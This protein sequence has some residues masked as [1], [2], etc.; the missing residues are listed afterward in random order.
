MSRARWTGRLAGSLTGA[1][2]LAVAPG[3]ATPAA[4][5]PFGPRSTA[6]TIVLNPD[7]SY[8]VTLRQTQ[9]LV[10][11]YQITFGGGVHDGFRLPDDGALLPPYLRAEYALTSVSAAEGQPEPADFTRTNHRVAAT[12]QGTYPTG[13]H[14]FEIS[15]RVTGAAQPTRRG[16]TVHVRLLDTVYSDGDRVEIRTDDIRSTRLSLRCVTYPPDSEPCGILSGT[17]L[18]DVFEN[19]RD[20]QHPPEFLIEVEADNARVTQ[21]TLDRR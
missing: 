10:R 9:Q 20:A 18:I 1:L 17:T 6:T 3:T 12:S 21:P 11:E 13:R 7:G 14:E 8:D 5:N 15:Y 19:D 4:P 2:L 16:W